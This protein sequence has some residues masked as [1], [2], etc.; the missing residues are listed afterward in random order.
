LIQVT[1][2]VTKA[3]YN[4]NAETT[5]P[6][7]DMADI[8]STFVSSISGHPVEMANIGSLSSISA[9]TSASLSDI[10]LGDIS[11]MSNSLSDISSASMSVS[12]I[13]SDYSPFSDT[14]AASMS[15]SMYASMSDISDSFASASMSDILDSDYA[16]A[17]DIS[18]FNSA[19]VSD[20]SYDISYSSIGDDSD[21]GSMSMS[22]SQ[23]ASL[24]DISYDVSDSANYGISRSMIDDSYGSIDED[25]SI[26]DDYSQI[27]SDSVSY[28]TAGIDSE[29]SID[30]DYSEYA[31]NIYSDYG[32]IFDYDALVDFDNYE[33][34]HW[35]LVILIIGS[36]IGVLAYYFVFRKNAKY[37]H[38]VPSAK[39]KGDAYDQLIRDDESGE[40]TY[41][42]DTPRV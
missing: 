37:R 32:A 31:E 21:Y 2:A 22:A 8:D 30:D 40:Y 41:D 9:D 26:D 39:K 19:S 13:E 14:S 24:S 7:T 10:S 6:S 16:S 36:V 23:S 20:I 28:N 34:H 4:S 33:A 15:A 27:E 3:V 11:D 25:Y 42:E 38:M 12:N 18:D 1:S 29:Y 17:S 35:G 5:F